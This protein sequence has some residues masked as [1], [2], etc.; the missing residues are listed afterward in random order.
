M[1]LKGAGFFGVCSGVFNHH[2]PFQTPSKGE[3]GQAL[4]LWHLN[5]SLRSQAV[6]N[7]SLLLAA[8]AQ[9]HSFDPLQFDGVVT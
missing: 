6:G 8:S 5:R 4:D 2:C 1:G 9:W 7:Y 3:R